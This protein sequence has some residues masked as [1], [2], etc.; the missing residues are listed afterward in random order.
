MTRL[1]YLERAWDAHSQ[2][3]AALQHAGV[4]GDY[5]H[6]SE[7]EETLLDRIEAEKRMLR[8]EGVRGEPD[9]DAQYD[10]MREME[11]VPW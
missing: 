2:L 10:Q 9:G 8:R 7:I 3:V 1:D 4:A 11:D 5:P 6:L